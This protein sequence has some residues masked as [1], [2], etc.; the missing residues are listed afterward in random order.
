MPAQYWLK[1]WFRSTLYIRGIKKDP[2]S[3]RVTNRGWDVTVQ[4]L[5]PRTDVTDTRSGWPASFPRWLK[6]RASGF[7]S[8]EGFRAEAVEP[9]PLSSERETLSPLIRE[10]SAPVVQYADL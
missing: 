7:Y 6:N 8:P 1:N 10:L 9:G 5:R 3:V 4:G 2:R